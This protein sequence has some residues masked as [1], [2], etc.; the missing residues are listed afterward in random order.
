VI[1]NYYNQFGRRFWNSVDHTAN[2]VGYEITLTE[3]EESSSGSIA[4]GITPSGITFQ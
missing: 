1:L 4:I 2:E 3:E